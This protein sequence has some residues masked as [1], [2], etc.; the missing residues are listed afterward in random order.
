VTD[1]PK[2]QE[3]RLFDPGAE[4]V[5]EISTKAIERPVW[6]ENKAD[7]IARYLRYFV[8]ITHHGTYIDPFAGPQTEKSATAWTA[9][10]VLASEP[11]WLRHFHLFDIDPAQVD[12]LHALKGDHDDR[13]ITVYP[14]GDS[15]RQLPERFPEG[16]I[17]EREAT[18]CLLD[19][20]TFECEWELCRHI[21]RLR[22]GPTKV[23]QFYFL[24]NSWLPRAIAGISTPEGEERVRRW[25]GNDDW[26]AFA[27]LS[28]VDRAEVFV[29]RF[30]EELGYRSVKAWPIFER[31]GGGTI[32][33]FMIHAT[34]HE[35]A[36][37]L[38]YRAYDKAVDPPEPAEQLELLLSRVTLE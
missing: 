22:P 26:R 33:Y 12:R 24:A 23:E 3:V 38:M 25:L 19:Q 30:R 21:S 17:G 7:L 36:P 32:M 35:E 16:S 29:G 31:A 1:G 20:R 15:N 18:F 37:K 13:G 11:K 14:P 6:S 5:V 28:S 9:Q 4:S 27:N 10:Q 34:D 2:W 8:F